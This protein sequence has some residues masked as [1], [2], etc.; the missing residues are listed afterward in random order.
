M[1]HHG[2]CGARM[3]HHGGVELEW[4]IMVVVEVD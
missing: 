2:G 1:D 4:I 3:D